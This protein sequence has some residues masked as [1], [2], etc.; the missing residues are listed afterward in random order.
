MKNSKNNNR[1]G[2]VSLY[3]P[4]DMI[5]GI[6]IFFAVP[7]L[8][9]GYFFGLVAAMFVGLVIFVI[10][11][12]SS[13]AIL[14]SIM[15]YILGNIKVTIS[16]SSRGNLVQERNFLFSDISD[17]LESIKKEFNDVKITDLSLTK[18][19]PPSALLDIKNKVKEVLDN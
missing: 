5:T 12:I 8:V 16:F 15:D 2:S 6:L 7:A 18:E 13:I 11:L 10:Y 1:E 17:E 14:N 9:S 19:V 4:G 3:T